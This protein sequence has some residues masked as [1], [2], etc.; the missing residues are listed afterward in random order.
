MVNQIWFKET[1]MTKKKWAK[2]SL[3]ISLFV[4]SSTTVDVQAQLTDNELLGKFL[5]FDK[6]LS[7]P[8]RQSCADCHAPRAGWTTPEPGINLNKGPHPGAVQQRSGARKPPTVSY[9]TFAP[10]FGQSG[11]RFS[12][13]NFWDGRATGDILGTPAEDQALAPF[14]SPVEM[15]LSTKQELCKKVSASHLVCLKTPSRGH[16]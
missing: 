15:N 5:F 1:D 10:D 14:F 6:K 8:S 9:A 11:G 16:F 2:F 12:G 4:I 3:V 7:N 13:G